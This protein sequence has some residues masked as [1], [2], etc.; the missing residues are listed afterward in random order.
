MLR[1]MGTF[2]AAATIGLQAGVQNNMP[3][4]NTGAGR[5]PKPRILFVED[6]ATLRDH[7]AEALSDV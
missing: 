4:K 1:G 5:A 3:E 7:L 6:E 2:L